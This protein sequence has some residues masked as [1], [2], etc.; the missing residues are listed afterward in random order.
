MSHQFVVAFQRVHGSNVPPHFS[1]PKP[2]VSS[3][4]R[5]TNREPLQES[6][7]I[8]VSASQSLEGAQDIQSPRC[9][10]PRHQLQVCMKGLLKSGTARGQQAKHVR[11]HLAP[12]HC[13]PPPPANGV[14]LAW[15]L[16]LFSQKCAI[17]DHFTRLEITKK[18]FVGGWTPPSPRPA[19]I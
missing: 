19:S 1:Y 9:F 18:D 3:E 15:T 2:Q 8:S 12:K 14:I 5:V 17:K 13:I 7:C 11:A 10:S 4:I 6:L 16:P